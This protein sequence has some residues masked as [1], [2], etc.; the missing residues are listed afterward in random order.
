[1]K[2]YFPVSTDASEFPPLVQQPVRSSESDVECEA[3][4]MSYGV[5][6][7]TNRDAEGAWRSQS[8]PKKAMTTTTHLAALGVR[9]C[10]LTVLRARS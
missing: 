2:I 6:S 7:I 8:Q 10:D 1:V 4:P 3:G 5:R 9:R